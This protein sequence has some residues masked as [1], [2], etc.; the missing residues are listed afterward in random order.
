MRLLW[1]RLI[2]CSLK[3]RCT[4][5]SLYIHIRRC[6]FYV[7]LL[8]AGPTSEQ[9]QQEEGQNLRSIPLPRL[10]WLMKR[11]G[12]RSFFLLKREGFY[13]LNLRSNT[14]CNTWRSSVDFIQKYFSLCEFLFNIFREKFEYRPLIGAKESDEMTWMISDSTAKANETGKLLMKFRN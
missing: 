9:G 10:K 6:I 14:I 13:Y 7:L 1:L 12:M 11:R 3:V 4:V 8:T 5:H 2:S